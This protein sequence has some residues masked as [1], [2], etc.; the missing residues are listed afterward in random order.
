MTSPHG[1]HIWYELLTPDADAAQAFYGPML[2]WSFR[3]AGM[4]GVDYRIFASPEADIGGLM[5][6]GEGMPA[7]WLGYVGV[8]DVD[9]MA[10]SVTDGGGAV[11]MPPADIPGVGRFALV[12]DPAG[13]VFYV[14][15]PT[16]PED[17]PD[18]QSLSFSYD[19]PRV[20]H[21]AWNELM[22]PDPD[23]ALAFYGQRFGWVKD[24]E[25]EMGP[26]GIYTF[27]RHGAK[28][29]MGA[30]MPMMPDTPLPAWSHYFRVADI[31]A[32]YAHVTAQGG[33]VVEEPTEIPGGAFSMKGIDPQG[34][35]FALVGARRQEG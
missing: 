21:C 17:A 29:M 24:G 19:R 15:A 3:D 14:M 9:A 8:D 1:D 4:P 32:A 20:G 6:A 16:L 11:H 35:A 5:P 7:A 22:T 27:L 30:V 25:M 33:R 2:G 23:A 26:L 10:K 34:V 13:A 18:A 31:D 28:G 12:A